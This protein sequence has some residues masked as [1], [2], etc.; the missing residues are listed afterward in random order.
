MLKGDRVVLRPIEQGD[1][2]RLWELVGDFEVAILKNPGP[3][4]PQSLAEFEANF[5]QD[6]SQHRKDLAYFAIE[7]EGEL[8]GSSGLH[9][10]DH[11]SRSCELGIGIGRGYWGKGFG[12][13]AV[14]TLVDYAFEHLNMNRVAL[15]CLAE[16]SRA[17]G[18]YRKVGFVE[19]G[20]QRELAW[21]R[22]G[23]E[24]VLMMAILREDWRPRSADAV[25]P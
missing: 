8:I 16:D 6:A 9:R 5:D 15:Q 24:D 10:I 23:Y 17:V 7:V 4:L 1:L 20:R 18:A 21:L 12:Q 25:G 11:F 2:P 3:V 19:E 13:D 22:G 14:R